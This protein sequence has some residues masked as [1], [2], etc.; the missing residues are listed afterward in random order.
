MSRFD[1][2]KY[3]PYEQLSENLKIVKDRSVNIPFTHT[4]TNT[5]TSPTC[6]CTLSHSLSLSSLQRPLTLSEKIVYSHLDD[7]K[8]QVHKNVTPSVCMCV[9]VCHYS[10]CSVIGD[11]TWRVISTTQT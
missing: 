10:L 5:H 6:T 8:N 7:P 4:N 2:D 1:P 11:R 9:C 3:I